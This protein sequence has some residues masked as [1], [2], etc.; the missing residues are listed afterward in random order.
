MKRPVEAA[1]VTSAATLYSYL[2][3]KNDASKGKH[4]CQNNPFEDS[5]SHTTEMPELENLNTF[6]G[7]PE[8]CLLPNK[9]VLIKQTVD[10]KQI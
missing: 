5:L 9:Y 1:D 6:G 8:T 2:I 4:S 10:F 7:R 3:L